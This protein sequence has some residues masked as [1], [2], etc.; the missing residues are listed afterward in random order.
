[1][2]SENIAEYTCEQEQVIELPP[3]ARAIVDAPAG[4]GKTH[5]LAGRAARLIGRDGL[6]AGDEVLIL[7]FSR[8]AVSELRVRVS[9]L[10]G[11][12]RY[13]G[14]S[15]FDAFATQLLATEEPDDSWLGVGYA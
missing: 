11:D 2:I 5:V 9:R 15:T 10:G 4:T 1:M 8:A 7:S 13:V 6:T 14:A 3:E 12:G